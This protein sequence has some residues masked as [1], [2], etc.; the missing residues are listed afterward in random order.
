MALL[1]AGFGWLIARGPLARHFDW[2]APV[3]G[4]LS[5]AFGIYYALGALG[6]VSYLL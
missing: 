6:V 5:L 3:L 2:V 1:S 4:G